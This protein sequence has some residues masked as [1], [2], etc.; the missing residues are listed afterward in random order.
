MKT[1]IEILKYKPVEATH[2]DVKSQKY[3]HI[4]N[5]YFVWDGEWRQLD[6]A[7]DMDLIEL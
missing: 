5:G 7:V 3:I 6:D 4:D 1:L 2:F